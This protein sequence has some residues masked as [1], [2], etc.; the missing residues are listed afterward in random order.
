VDN[1]GYS[2]WLSNTTVMGLDFMSDPTVIAG[3]G[4]AFTVVPR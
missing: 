3:M 4:T 1:T 2:D